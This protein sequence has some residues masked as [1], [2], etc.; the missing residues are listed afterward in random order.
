MDEVANESWLSESTNEDWGDFNAAIEALELDE[1]SVNVTD[2]DNNKQS[3]TEQDRDE[4]VAGF[5][6]MAFVLTEQAT[7]AISGVEFT[8]DEKGKQKVIEAAQPVLSKHG[9]SMMS[10]FGQ[11]IEEATLLMAIVALVYSSRMT[12]LSLKT[13]SLNEKAEVSSVT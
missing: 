8:F 2:S 11:Y 12:I 7:C 10:V 13:E 1:T 9:S 6:E 5:L 4:A 3:E